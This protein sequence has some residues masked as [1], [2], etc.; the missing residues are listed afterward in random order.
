[1]STIVLHCDSLAVTEYADDFTGLAG[2]YEATAAGVHEVG[3]ALDVAAKIASTVTFGLSLADEPGHRQRPKQLV[4]HGTGLSAMEVRV[5]DS[6][7]ESYTYD[8]AQI[9][10]RAARFKLGKGL[11]DNYL[12]ISLLSADPAFVVDRIEFDPIVAATRRL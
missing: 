7:D 8:N 9:H 11:R 2:D 5:T 10:G 6:Q 3:G 12:Q 4:V 1:M